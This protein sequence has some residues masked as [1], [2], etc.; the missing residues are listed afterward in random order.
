MF[1]RALGCRFISDL[2]NNGSGCRTSSVVGLGGCVLALLVI[3]TIVT[4]FSN[5]RTGPSSSPS[6][7]RG[8]AASISRLAAIRGSASLS[9]LRG[10]V[11]SGGRSINVTCVNCIN[12]RTGRRRICDFL[13]GDRCTSGCSFLYNSPLMGINNTRLCTMIVTSARCVTSICQ[14]RVASGNR[15]SMGASST[16][17]GCDNCKVSCFLLHYGRDRVRSGMS[18]L[19]RGK[20]DSFSIFP[21]LSKVSKRLITRGF[22]SFSV[23][24][25]C[26]S[27]DR[28]RGGGITVTER[29][30][31]RSRRIRC[32]VGVNVDI[33]CAKRVRRVCNHPY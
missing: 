30:L 3:L 27:S 10:A 2:I 8:G 6:L 23:C 1:G 16:V 12:C 17:C 19:F 21:V 11:L 28:T 7:A 25:S 13:S 9:E 31:L 26:N 20:G 5:Y 4:T 24:D 33:R 18:L 29:V 32:C 14:T 22:C 15:C